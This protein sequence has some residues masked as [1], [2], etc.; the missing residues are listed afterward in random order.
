[1]NIQL[2][3]H[4]GAGQRPMAQHIADLLKRCAFAN[5]VDCEAV[6]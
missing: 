1:M 2:G 3:V 4:H 5:E 6:T